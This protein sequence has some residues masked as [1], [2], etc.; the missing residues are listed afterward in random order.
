MVTIW[1][2]KW[3]MLPFTFNLFFSFVSLLLNPSLRHHR[4]KKMGKG[5]GEDT[6]DNT[7]GIVESTIPKEETDGKN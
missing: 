2:K 6:V 5:K 7:W 1:M 4:Y 3:A